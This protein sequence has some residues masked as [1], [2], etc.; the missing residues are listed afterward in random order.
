MSSVPF[1]PYHKWLGIPLAEQPAHHYRLLGIP[2]YEDDTQVVEAAADRHMAFLRKFQAGE[3]AADATRILNEVSRAR[4]CLLRPAS[5]QEYDSEL[6][7]T[8]ARKAA[9]PPLWRQPAALITASVSAIAAIV[10]VAALNSS[11]SGPVTDA[12]KPPDKGGTVQQSATAP[13]DKPKGKSVATASPKTQKAG[14]TK[15]GGAGETRPGKAP[16]PTLNDE[17]DQPAGAA[18]K[19]NKSAKADVAE[20]NAKDD[21][22]KPAVSKLPRED[23]ALVSEND[24]GSSS[25]PSIEKLPTPDQATQQAALKQVREDFQV[26]YS[27]ARKAE[28]RKLE[29]RIALANALYARAQGEGGD[30]SLNYVM[31]SEAAEYASEAGQLELSWKILETL[32]ERYDVTPLPLMQKAAKAAK[33]FAKNPQEIAFLAS[34]YVRLIDEAIQADDFETASKAGVEANTVTR[35]I[36]VL[37]EQL[38]A[39]T[40]LIGQLREVYELAKPARLRAETV[41]DDGAANL[42]WGRYLCFFKKNWKAGLPLLAKSN[43]ERLAE[44]AKR[45]LNQKA[46]VEELTRLGDDWWEIAAGE[47]DPSQEMIREHAVDLWQSAQSIASENQQATLASRIVRIFENTKLFDTTGSGQGITISGKEQNPGPYFTAEFWIATK[48]TDGIL[49]SKRHKP[50]DTSIVLALRGGRVVAG[51]DTSSGFDRFQ[52]RPVINDGDWHHV[53]IVKIR[54]RLGLFIDGKWA[55][56]HDANDVYISHSPWKIGYQD[57]STSQAIAARFCRI[58]LSKDARYLVNFVPEKRYVTDKSTMLMVR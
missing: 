32:G 55:G 27:L 33:P 21:Q 26:E 53:A 23:Q 19:N 30:P 52:S 18:R 20:V 17:E 49:I 31:L 22:Q 42:T 43:D 16:W 4:L 28:G 39:Y 37:K 6:K 15:A 36:P 24:H 41:P 58:R 48:A 45:D 47:K 12:R 10:V 34:M 11:G 13:S 57:T 38:V 7:R 54:K 29:P 46:D 5:K 3:H 51:G 14:A 35:S 9:G 50:S 2:L 25:E 56:N 1:D 8:L 44:V 40:R